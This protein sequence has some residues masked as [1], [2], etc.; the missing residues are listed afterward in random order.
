L[1]FTLDGERLH[2]SWVLV[3]MKQDRSGGKRTNWL[4]IK[5]RD[6][7][8]RSGGGAELMA[9][10]R[11]VA[12][13]R[14]MSEIAAGKGRPPKPFMVAGSK[15][16][17]AN[18]VWKS[19]RATRVTAMIGKPAT[20]KPAA[21]GTSVKSPVEAAAK[22]PTIKRIPDFIEPQLCRL[23]EVPPAQAGWGHE[24]KF[25]G[26]R[27][28]LRVA[29]GKATLK[30][31]SALDWTDRFSSIA[32]EAADLPDCLIDG[33]VVALDKR[34][35]PNFSALQAAL[36]EG[37]SEDLVF[38]AF[39]LLFE[40][41]S[42]LRPLPLSER[43]ARLEQLL[44]KV[45]GEH[46]R[47][48][49]HLE[50]R[51]DSVLK[52]AC[53]MGLEGIVSKRLAAPYLSGRGDSWQKSKCRAGHEVVLGGWTTEAG[54]LRSLLAGVNRDGHLIYVGRIGTGYTR[55]T[56]E[57]LLPQLKSLTVEE[58]PFGGENAP[59]RERNVRWL[60]PELV[61]EIEFAGWTDSGMIRQAAFKGLRQ[62][63]PASEVVA[64]KP[65]V[66]DKTDSGPEDELEQRELGTERKGRRGAARP[67]AG[68]KA[69]PATI[70][71]VTIS[72]PD[73][74]LWPDAGDGR[75]VTKLDLARYFEQMGAFMLPH[76]EGRPCS[77][78][79]A[80][81]GIGGQSFF[82]R[83]AMAGMS[84]LF[85]LVKVKGDRAPYVQIDRVEALAAVAQIG[86][87]E[88]HPWNCVPHNP[89][90]AGRLVFDLDPA[91]DVKF[92]AVVDAAL[93]MRERLRA[94]GLESF[95]KSTGGKGLHV[96]TPLDGSRSHG[97]EWPAAKNFAHVVCAQMT[98]DSPT[99]YLD[100]MSKSQR[101]GRIFL[102][103]LRNDRIATAV[104][105]LSPRARAGAPVS[106]PLNWSEVRHGLDP[107]RFTVRTAPA[108]LTKSKA[109]KGYDESAKSLADAIRKITSSR[110]A[111]KR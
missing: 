73:K 8:A 76:I 99:K 88:L 54:T 100:N 79:R 14:A 85:E 18:A 57:Q 43:K 72:K 33:E 50:S 111:R 51:G 87:L 104:A 102:D 74:P 39:D 60:R 97:V 103:Y 20:R 32:E 24:V 92:D 52:S 41:R 75:P 101:V 80:P 12:S 49:S 82:Q 38:F 69:G 83:H 62:D 66:V 70:M 59:R 35:V 90:I 81:D 91:L 94:V 1:K 63:K 30:T 45:A 21:A 105:P 48:V 40:K 3:R 34:R 78:V 25:D 61:A 47:Y 44:R 2:G 98:Q 96:V 55:K 23:V 46:I 71:G 93:E 107:M 17:R 64:E 27:L 42:D 9:D 36:S 37:R 86:A 22:A 108:L 28:Q 77:M 65:R 67:A 84:E 31:R 56:A 16:A 89:E 26:Y 6:A 109:W 15:G 4:L 5:H 106:M 58:S 13:G 95:C 11:S 19:D 7:S 53:A 10:D 29:D 68:R 110:G